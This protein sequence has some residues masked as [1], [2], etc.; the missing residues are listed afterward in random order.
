MA[1]NKVS[2]ELTI[3]DV[4]AMKS[5]ENFSKKINR[6]TKD[7]EGLGKQTSKVEK[8]TKSFF[9][10]LSEG[11]NEGFGSIAKGVTIANLATE[12]ILGVANSMKQ[13]V[14]NSINGAIEAEQ[15]VNKLSQALRA[16]GSYS[17]QAVEDFKSY[18]DALEL[19]SI[20]TAEQIL[21]QI[22]LAKQMGATN[23][24]AKLL[25][26]AAANLSAVFGGSLEGSAKQL[27]QTL[28]GDLGKLGKLVP[29]LKDLTSEQLRSGA[30][31]EII[32]TKFSGAAQAQ[33]EGYAGKVDVLNKMWGKFQE[34]VG[35][36]VIQNSSVIGSIELLTS[37]FISLASVAADV[38]SA[39]NGGMSEDQHLKMLDTLSMK[40]A[41]LTDRVEAYGNQIRSF[42][43]G[44][45]GWF[46]KIGFDA[47]DAKS[48]VKELQEQQAQLYK[49]MTQ[50]RGPSSS[51][52]DTSK[53]DV[54][55]DTTVQ[56]RANALAQLK[57]MEAEYEAWKEELRIANTELTQENFNSELMALMTSEQA[58]IDAKYAAEEAKIAAVQDRITRESQLQALEVKKRQEVDKMEID[59]TKKLNTQL[60]A[61]EQ[62]KQA[63]IVGVMGAGFEMMAAFAKDGSREQFLIQK[64]AA[65]AES[66][67]AT[68]MA[69]AKAMAIDP[70]GSLAAWAYA[71][72]MMKVAT[73]TATTIKGFA[74]GGIVDS[75]RKQGDQNIIRVNGGEAV[76]T[77]S[78]Q[79]K[80]MDI[81]NGNTG[82]GGNIEQ[83]IER[84]IEVIESRPTVISIDGRE[85]ARS[86]KEQRDMG[87]N[88]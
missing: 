43:S 55:D 27:G 79:Q 71:Q 35:N 87:Y 65:L 48:K 22:G 52:D 19:T 69:A 24:E 33:V 51:I 11:A 59:S 5:L 14:L 42:E 49:Q 23:S 83:I 41:Q 18:A 31:L 28:N 56:N 8:E 47:E 10:S 73:I 4:A 46:E 7:T 3:E 70:T 85:I 25:A 17:S 66:V 75:N 12:G 63:A 53:R 62:Q 81:A 84:V 50:E 44:E 82:V 57:A 15:A 6:A 67:I 26:T 60:V 78:Q 80:F 54:A 16:S 32:N 30:A 39:L 61:L 88:V 86:V 1:D 72:G 21:D 34:E 74:M 68:N 64:A 36:V 77:Q 58:K 2:I 20:Y 76:L 13:F 29:E 40:Y 45:M 9:Q 37:A 38:N